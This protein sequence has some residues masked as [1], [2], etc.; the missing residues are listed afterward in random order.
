MDFNDNS[1]HLNLVL[2]SEIS[3]LNSIS[4]LTHVSTDGEKYM[5]RFQSNNLKKLL[6][7]KQSVEQETITY[8]IDNPK[9]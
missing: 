6:E 7:I 3:N 8:S 2:N 9:Y 1:I 5:Y 4:Q